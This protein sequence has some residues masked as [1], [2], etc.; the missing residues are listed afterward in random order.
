MAYRKDGLLTHTMNRV[1]LQLTPIVHRI[2]ADNRAQ[3]LHWST[4]GR[5]CAKTPSRFVHIRGRANDLFTLVN[6]KPT[7]N[8]PHVFHRSHHT[9]A[10]CHVLY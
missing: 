8:F 7:L 2:V 10:I 9:Q 5:I 4:D 1:T 6:M 3:V